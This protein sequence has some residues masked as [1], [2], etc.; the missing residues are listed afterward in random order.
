MVS[1]NVEEYLEA[2]CRLA[3]KGEELTTS[4]IA[5]ELGFSPPSVSE[6]LKKLDEKGYL[7]YE[8]Y[9]G[10]TLTK[11]GQ[12]LGSRILRKHRLLEKFLEKLGVSKNRIHEE[13]CK[14]EHSIS[15]ELEKAIEKQISRP[16]YK[17]GVVSLVDLRPGQ[18]GEVVSVETGFRVKR[19]L[20]EMGLT[21][22]TRV[23]I[24]K[25]ALFGGPVEILV[26][27]SR[28]AIGRGMARR[29]FVRV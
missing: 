7:N 27:G 9:K 3:E 26:R 21:P 12:E 13:A 19:R 20:E 17:K 11:R 6:M 14:L 22:G 25:S 4:N 16:S 15:E 24:V 5:K 2:I 23:R 1:E 10:V 8:P 28:L 29:I 18:A